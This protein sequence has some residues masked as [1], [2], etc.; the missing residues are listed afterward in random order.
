MRV[1]AKVVGNM[2]VLPDEVA[3][4]EGGA[5]DVQLDEESERLLVEAVEA[6][7]GDT[8]VSGE[9]MTRQLQAAGF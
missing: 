3:P 8:A 9:E 2:L 1:T 4:P 5:G 7:D 6:I